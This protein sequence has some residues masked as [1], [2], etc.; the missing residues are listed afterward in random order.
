MRFVICGAGAVGGVL[1]GQLAKAGCDV[2]FIEPLPDHAAALSAYGLSLTGVHGTHL[3]HI[4]TVQQAWEVA[5][6]ADDVIVLAV[7]TFHCEAAVTALRRA[8]SYDL[9]VF[10]AQNGVTNEGLVA[11]AFPHVHG[12]M[13]LIGAK[14]LTPGVVVH[15]G[16]G[17]VGIGT[18]PQGLSAV[19][20]DVA[21]ALDETDLPVYT[22]EHIVPEKWNKLLINLNNATL[23]VSGLATQ[24]AYADR[25]ARRWMAAV[26]D[27]GARVL[28]AA[29]IA[30]HGPPGMGAI[31]DRIRE[32]QETPP[33]PVLSVTDTMLGRSSLWQ[34]LWHQRG[35]VEAEAL[36]GVIVRLGQQYH[37]PTPYNSLLL[38]LLRDMAATRTLP[39]R[40]P[41]HEL[42]ARLPEATLRSGERK[43]AQSIIAPEEAHG[44]PQHP[45][46]RAARHGRE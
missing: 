18:Y 3:L 15:T 45:E 1:G 38:T 31:E 35:E 13:L 25:E 8:T 33:Y 7:K 9:H 29:G 5:F 41:L 34:D 17:P 4:P 19:A 24:E 43:V 6:R 40:Y 42:W 14:R 23:G 46:C 37:V 12:M 36:N 26:W 10:C 22:T 28:R 20:Q 2:L 11:G 27:E 30:Y 32:L 16:N 21:A 44:H 39:G